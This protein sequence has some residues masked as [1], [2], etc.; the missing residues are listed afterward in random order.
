M[1]PAAPSWV[2]RLS[3]ETAH[4]LK[5]EKFFISAP[6]NR[7]QTDP[8]SLNWKWS[9]LNLESEERF[10]SGA[11]IPGDFYNS[12]FG[13]SYKHNDG[14]KKFWGVTA[15]VG[16]AGDQT[17]QSRTK[18]VYSANAFYSMSDDLTSRWLW[19][20]NYSNNRSFLN[21]IP[22]PGVAYIYRPS[23]DFMGIFGFPFAM[24]RLKLDDLWSST[25]LVGPYIYKAELSRRIQGPLQ[26]YLSADNGIQSFY[27]EARSRD[28]DR[29][30][31]SESRAL[32]GLKTPLRSGLFIDLFA[33]F[34][35][36][37]SVAETEDF[38]AALKDENAVYLPNRW[39]A[40]AQL[41]FRF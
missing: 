24:I 11:P 37:R 5:Q 10:E 22:I 26:A 3:G 33:G 32:L 6:V 23:A 29:V 18:T 39:L 38:Q 27:R 17:F 36:S 20:V 21:H 14:E 1:S 2:L 34:V 28:D 8:A 40:G 35:Y 16:S 9:H 31:Y 25:W 41:S 15:S 13:L 12:E 30:F 7:N 4:P 19:I